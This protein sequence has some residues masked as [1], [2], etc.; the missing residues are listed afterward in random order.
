MR[1]PVL[2]LALLQHIVLVQELRESDILLVQQR[3]EVRRCDQVKLPEHGWWH[4]HLPVVEKRTGAKHRWANI[5]KSY[6]LRWTEMLRT[7]A[8]LTC[9]D[10]LVGE[11]RSC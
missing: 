10:R 3:L 2:G 9:R 6:S 1:P 7:C 8:V 5:R 11:I 4:I